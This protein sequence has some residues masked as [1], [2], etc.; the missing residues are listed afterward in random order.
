MFS[1]SRD[2]ARQFFFDTWTKY[3]AGEALTGLESTALEVILAHAEYHAILDRP[4]QYQHRDY[5]PEPGD[6]NPFLHLSLHL[7]IAEQLAID[8]PRGLRALYDDLAREKADSHAALHDIL[9]CLGETIWQAQRSGSAPDETFYLD[10][11]R[12]RLAHDKTKR[13]P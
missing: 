1:P 11:V 9:E 2:Q 13:S 7:A 4:A 3:R 8:Q 5:L 6:I 12:Q 10:C